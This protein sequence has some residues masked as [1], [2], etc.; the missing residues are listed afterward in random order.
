MIVLFVLAVL[1]ILIVF[2]SNSKKDDVEKRERI[3]KLSNDIYLKKIEKEKEYTLEGI[4][5]NIELVYQVDDF[6]KTEWIHFNNI[7]QDGYKYLPMYFESIVDDL[8]SHKHIGLSF[9]LFKNK[10]YL[11]DVYSYGVNEMGLAKGDEL[12]LIFENGDKI[13]IVFEQLRSSQPGFKSNCYILN[14]NELK[15]FSN[16]KLDK[17]K[18]T[19]TKRNIY[20]VG[21]NS[22]FFE[23]CKIKSKNISQ[24]VLKHLATTIINVHT[25]KRSKV[26]SVK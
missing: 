13:D 19:S 26:H 3:E 2:I 25:K 24:E 18:L 17:W 22:I 4:I 11:L 1:I 16:E 8:V 20:V 23:R 5:G 6:D 10:T 15:T 7:S 14:E 12:K 21:D 9:S